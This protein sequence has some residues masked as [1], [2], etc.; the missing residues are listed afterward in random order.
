MK[1]IKRT[2]KTTE[3]GGT[4]IAMFHPDNI[5]EIQTHL[6]SFKH[7]R[8]TGHISAISSLD[9]KNKKNVHTFKILN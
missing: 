2:Y 8:G 1:R 5:I 3:F 7:K 9:L 6:K 4:A